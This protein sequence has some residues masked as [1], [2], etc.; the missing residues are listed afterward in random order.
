MG[1]TQLEIERVACAVEA[2]CAPFRPL[3]EQAHR[4]IIGQ[5]GLLHRMLVGLLSSGRTL[6]KGVPGLAKTLVVSCLARGIN[7]TFQRLQFTP[8]LLPADLPGTLIFRPTDRTFVVQNGPVFSNIILAD[9]INRAPAKVQSALLEAMQE[10]QVTIGR[11]TYQAVRAVPAAGD[12]KPHRTGGN[13]FH[14]PRR[15]WTGSC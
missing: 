11:D 10:R 5:D 3:P 14:Y 1:T 4:V 7:T 15:R 8:D 6:I 13:L 9:E 2:A 12:P